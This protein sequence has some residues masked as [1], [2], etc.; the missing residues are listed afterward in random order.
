MRLIWA[1]G[2]VILARNIKVTSEQLLLQK[3]NGMGGR[4]VR[5][6][7]HQELESLEKNQVYILIKP[8]YKCLLLNR[9][10]SCFLTSLLA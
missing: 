2:D 7:S 6:N 1:D 9:F 4:S 5:H 8:L 3:K 10:E